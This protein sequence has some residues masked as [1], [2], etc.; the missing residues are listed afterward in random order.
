MKAI[1]QESYGR[2]KDVFELREIDKPTAGEGEVLVRVR[3]TC[4][5]PDVW[6]AI[7][8]RPYALRLMGSGFAR[9]KDGVPGMDLAGL[10]EAIGPDVTRFEPGDA[11]FGQ[12]RE[13]LQWR[14][15][16]AF[17]EY[18]SV[19]E[20]SLA[21]KPERVSFE[22]AASVPTSGFIALLNLRGS[23]RLEPG[24]SVLVNGAAGG[25]GSIAV[26]L[27]KAR[28]A[29]V[30]GVDSAEKLEL[31]RSLG[32]DDVIDYAREDFTRSGKR[33]DLILDVA[34]NLRLRD[35][36]RA[37]T[38]EGTYVLIGHD[39]F[40]AATG[41]LLGS[42]PRILMLMALSPFVGH[43]PQS[44]G[45]PLPKTC[46]VMALLAELLENGKL[47]PVIDRSYPLEEAADAM[48][49]LQSGRAC[50]RVIITP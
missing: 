24:K 29:R 49:Y 32:A 31:V 18:V 47:T 22:Q 23:A 46:E 26:Q 14:N 1:V 19:P 9:P 6:H 39:H 3:A 12:T 48:L 45:A 4:A 37:L 40:G 28:G 10:V 5:H 20:S 36:K 44:Q 8:G 30:T 42:I 50:G 16:G 27:G 21:L 38:P 25:L 33:Y 7:T 41:R 35:C 43:L 17:A 2:P 15:G 11:V 34:S 13:E